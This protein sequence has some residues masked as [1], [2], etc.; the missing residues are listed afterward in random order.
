ME[1]YSLVE[2]NPNILSIISAIIV[3]L[4][5][6]VFGPLVVTWYK[7]RLESNRDVVSDNLSFHRGIDQ[8]LEFLHNEMESDLSFIAQFH[9]GGHFYPSGKSIQKFSIFYEKVESNDDSLK[10]ILNQIPV[11]FFSKT[12]SN[13]NDVGEVFIPSTEKNTE[14]YDLNLFF[15]EKGFSSYYLFALEDLHG[16]FVGFLCLTYK[17]PYELNTEDLSFLYKETSVIGTLLSNYLKP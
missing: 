5:V 2:N 15:K 12:L 11:S 10:A 7:K 3:A 16:H 1:P 13:L 17:E 4:I 8:R 6:S 9:N 14:E